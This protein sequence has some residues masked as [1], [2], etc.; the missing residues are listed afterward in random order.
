MSLN[1]ECRNY[2]LKTITDWR[3]LDRRAKPQKE[4]LI[5]RRANKGEVRGC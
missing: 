4:Q 5:R 3:M 2:T 1:Y